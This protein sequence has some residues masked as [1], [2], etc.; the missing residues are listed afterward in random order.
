MS[1]TRRRQAAVARMIGLWLTGAGITGCHG[2]WRLAPPADTGTPT[3]REREP[4]SSGSGGRTHRHVHLPGV[5]RGAALYPVFSRAVAITVYREGQWLVDSTQ[6]RLLA[7]S[8]AQLAPTLVSSFFVFAP[9]E[10][11][12]A[13]HRALYAYLKERLRRRVPDARF[14]V[15]LDA[16]GYGSGPQVV[17]HLRQ[18]SD[19]LEPDLWIFENWEVADRAHFAIVASAT[20]QAHANGQAIGGT[21]DADEMAMDSDFGVVTWRGSVAALQ[22]Q[23]R[24]LSTNHALPYL[25]AVNETDPLPPLVWP[26]IIRAFVLTQLTPAR[27]LPPA[28]PPSATPRR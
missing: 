9:D 24:R 15:R 22:R 13:R 7:D 12:S 8:L 4:A 14:D 27:L 10:V 19:A 11:P 21:T 26:P 28:A 2:T 23:L 25:I 18:L 5:V 17:D 3:Q 20:A 6:E 1:N 16:M